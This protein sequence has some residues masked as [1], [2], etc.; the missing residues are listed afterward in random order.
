MGLGNMNVLSIIISAVFEIAAVLIMLIFALL[1][2]VNKF[3]AWVAFIIL[4]IM[5]ILGNVYYSYEYIVI[6]STDKFW[7]QILMLFTDEFDVNVSRFIL[8]CILG[9][10]VPSISLL[11][12]K[13]M[14]DY[15]KENTNTNIDTT[16]IDKTEPLIQESLKTTRGNSRG[17]LIIKKS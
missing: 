5:Q 16:N 10:P 2:K 7:Q 4:I 13:S 15:L 17:S 3:A 14:N 12:A 11:L 6:N 9:I 8:A 1:P